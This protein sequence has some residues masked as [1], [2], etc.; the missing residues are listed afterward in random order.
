MSGFSRR[1]FLRGTGAAVAVG[2]FDTVS[3][4]WVPQTAHA[5]RRRRR[6]GHVPIPRLDGALVFDPT[7]I[8]EAATDFGYIITQEPW[9]V[10]QPGSTE[11][12]V[13]MVR[14]CGHH[15]LKIAMR[16]Q[17]HAVYGQAQAPGGVVID[18]RTLD[19]L[20]PVAGDH[21]WADAGVTWRDLVGATTAQG[22]APE[23]L[24]DYL[25][26]SVGGVLSVG[27]IGGTA[28]QKGLVTDTCEELEVVTGDGRKLR[29]SPTRHPRLFHSVLGGLGQFAIILR[30]KIRL[31]AQPPMA[32]IYQLVYPTLGS[33]LADQRSINAD[34]R[35]DFIEGQ[36]APNPSGGWLFVIQAGKWWTD[37]PPDDAALLSGLSPIPGAEEITDL[38]FI[39]WANRVEQF[40]QFW[41]A[42]GLYTSPH[43]WSD[44]FLP[45]DAVEAYVSD[46]L[47]R[48][49]PDQVGAG[50]QL[51]YPFKRSR[52]GESMV[53]LPATETLWLY[54]VL[55]FPMGDLAFAEQLVQ[56]NR[57]LYEDA[58][59]VGGKRYPIS[60]VPF[61]PPDW[62]QHY[63]SD[64]FR[65]VA[66]KAR[67]DRRNT[68]TPGQGI[69]L[70]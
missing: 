61:S 41:V 1:R 7:A 45:D 70:R 63:G 56:E 51:L 44:L 39:A 21:V 25:G 31:A 32:R 43:P 4:A 10:L 12:I 29:C 62:V 49:T 17:A 53:Q 13:R 19:T 66:S 46:A 60:A 52:V 9:A 26:L 38:P 15:D 67:F 55:R 54:D 3:Q 6:R 37:A 68:L 22:L 34:E 42:N 16:G 20:D 2:A 11:D 50:V 47:A 64:W 28:H 24:T 35:F 14:W 8:A 58:A 18:S 69:F 5:H 36:V 27:G 40:V 30:A 65:V 33:F 23:V 57:R 59:A 48:L